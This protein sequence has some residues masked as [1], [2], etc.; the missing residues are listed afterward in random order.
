[1]PTRWTHLIEK[2]S[3]RFKELE[4]VRTDKPGNFFGTCSK[5]QLLWLKRDEPNF[6]P[7]PIPSR[8]TRVAFIETH[9]SHEF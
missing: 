4:H 1:L 3:L 9:I 5:P 7:Q 8:K 6:V 2:E